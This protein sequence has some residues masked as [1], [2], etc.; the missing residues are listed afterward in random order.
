MEVERKRKEEEETKAEAKRQLGIELDKA[1]AEHRKKEEQ[2]KAEAERLLEEEA[3]QKR[4]EEEDRRSKEDSSQNFETPPPIT[5]VQTELPAIKFPA[6]NTCFVLS[7]PGTSEG[8]E[9]E[10]FNLTRLTHDL[11]TFKIRQEK[12]RCLAQNPAAPFKTTTEKDI[13]L[14][15]NTNAVMIAS[16]GTAFAVAT[17]ENV[18]WMS[19]EIL[20]LQNRLQ[21]SE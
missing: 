11:F 15:T 1:E 13:V 12:R 20:S 18:S 6:I 16:A 3:E 10:V 19:R 4:K 8:Q 2:D 5:G 7:Q 21:D 14:D 9:E 17:K